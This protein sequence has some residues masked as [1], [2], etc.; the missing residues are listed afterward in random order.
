MIFYYIYLLDYINIIIIIQCTWAH[1]TKSIQTP[2][3]TNS[4]LCFIYVLYLVTQKYTTPQTTHEILTG[5]TMCTLS[6][7]YLGYEKE[8]SIENT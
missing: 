2:K 6:N 1:G 5:V 8:E 4:F 3:Y 7:E